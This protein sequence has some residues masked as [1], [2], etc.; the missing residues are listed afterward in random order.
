MPG[1]LSADVLFILFCF[2]SINRWRDTSAM[3]HYS[4]IW[5]ISFKI[6]EQEKHFA[7]SGKSQVSARQWGMLQR[8][9]TS[10]YSID[11]TSRAADVS[12]F[13]T[14]FCFSTCKLGCF[15]CLFM[16][17]QLHTVAA[18]TNE[19]ATLKLCWN[20]CHFIISAFK[21]LACVAT[22]G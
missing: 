22:R 21:I 10:R 5:V 15:D 2:S 3:L 17:Q 19:F 20:V 4:Y 11:Y 13:A 8:Y 16:I 9:Y 14:M 18:L 1:Q 12:Y 7:R 6:R